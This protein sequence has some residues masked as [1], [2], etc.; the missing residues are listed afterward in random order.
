MNEVFLSRILPAH[1]LKLRFSEF[2]GLPAD[3]ITFV[4]NFEALSDISAGK[5]ALLE[6]LGGEFP[7]QI[8]IYWQSAASHEELATFLARVFAV[9][10]LYSDDTVNP[11]RWLVHANGQTRAVIVDSDALDEGYFVVS[12]I[13]D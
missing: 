2:Y 11:F 5:F 1:D 12:A 3:A 4:P 7:Q 9:D 6:T 10:V 13:A 8:S